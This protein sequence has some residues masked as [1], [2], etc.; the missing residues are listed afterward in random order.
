MLR[1]TQAVFALIV[2]TLLTAFMACVGGV[3][4]DRHPLMANANHAAI[5]VNSAFSGPRSPQ[6]IAVHP[7][8]IT[9][10]LLSMLGVYR[11]TIIERIS[12]A[13]RAIEI[14]R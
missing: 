4:A 2:L 11:S 10:E 3:R 12:T 13:F 7:A 8:T 9:T 5:G 6:H 1:I 14:S